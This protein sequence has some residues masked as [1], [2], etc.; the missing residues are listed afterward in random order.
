MILE[1]IGIVPLNSA[2]LKCNCDEKNVVVEDEVRK[3]EEK[4]NVYPETTESMDETCF[5]NSE[6]ISMT[7]IYSE[8]SQNLPVN[9]INETG[10]LYDTNFDYINKHL[11]N[12]EF[13]YSDKDRKIAPDFEKLNGYNP[14]KIS[15]QAEHLKT[16][17]KDNEVDKLNFKVK[18]DKKVT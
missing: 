7:T 4:T 12:T 8:S 2:D 14:M 15:I 6:N 13:K 18:N 1:F 16:R 5:Q 11:K 17:N 3:M 10:Y 9:Y